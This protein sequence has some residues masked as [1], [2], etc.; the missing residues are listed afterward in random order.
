[1]KRLRTPILTRA[2]AP[3][4]TRLL[5]R[6]LA[7]GVVAFS[8][9]VSIIAQAPSAHA[10]EDNAVV[11]SIKP[12]H[13][14]VAAV[15]QGVGS[16]HLIV[17][18]GASPHTYSLRPSDAQ[19]LQ[20]AKA[21]FWIGDELETFLAKPVASLGKDAKLVTL[22]EAH[23]LTRLKFREGGPFEAHD[24]EDDDH[25]AKGH[26]DAE[27]HDD[28]KSEHDEK[29]HAEEHG[30]SDEHEHGHDEIDMHVWLDPLNAKAMVHEIEETLAAIDPA[31]A[32][33]YEANARR[34]AT[35]LDALT[36]EVAAELAPVRN[37]PFVVF[38][39]GYQYFEAR[40]GMSA[41][42][43]ITV[44]PDAIPGAQ[45]VAEI[46]KRVKELGG[47]CVFA[48]PQFEPRLVKVVIEGTDAKSA[49]LDP[50]G[51]G[52]DDGPELYFQLIRNMS[53]AFTGCLSKPS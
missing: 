3:L 1:M 50:L 29:E 25:Q 19:K 16:P 52:L 51:A 37:S 45:R 34:L 21:I 24:H 15:M 27:H 35:Q 4:L 31:N 9:G 26:D 42:G 14:L 2:L 6:G 10:L 7:M 28:H 40:F 23:G 13:S 36:A 17:R 11:T 12:V 33:T 48:E 53:T 39:D 32:A 46:Q 22:S 43:S 47:T 44:N 30:H 49:V 20:Q 5:A 8:G 41:A 18:G 38:H